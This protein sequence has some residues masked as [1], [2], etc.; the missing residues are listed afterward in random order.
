[1]EEPRLD[2][3]GIFKMLGGVGMFLYGMG[4]MS[5]GLK[6]VAGDNMRIILEKTTKNRILGT[7]VGF[8]VTALI[9]SSSATTVM[10]IGFVGAGMMS[11]LQAIGVIMGANIG[12]TVTAQIVALD[13]GSVAPIILFLGVIMVTFLGKPLVRNIG[14]I[15]LGFGLLFTGI[16]TMSAAISPLKENEAFTG[17]LLTLDNPFI[18]IMFGILFTAIVQSSSSSIGI[19]QAFAAQGLITF[20]MGAYFAVGAAIGA[21]V[22]AFLAA[23]SANRDGKRVA[24]MDLLFNCF[25]AVLIGALLSIFPQLFTLIERLSPGDVARQIA[26]AHTLF[27][28][29]AVIVQ[30]PLAQLLVKLSVKIL[31]L[32]EDELQKNERKLVY[33]TQLDRIPAAVALSQARRE[34]VRMGRIT[35]KNLRRSVD[36]FF[37]YDEKRI[38]AVFQEEEVI[39][40]LAREITGGLVTLRAMDLTLREQNLLGQML[41]VVADIERIGDHA[42]NIAEYAQ[43]LYNQKVTLSPAAVEELQQLAAASIQS[44][45]KSIQVYEDNAFDQ[46]KAVQ[47]LEDEIDEM[48]D[49]AMD[50]HVRRFMDQVCQ[51]VGGVIFTDMVTDLERCS[52]HAVNIAY[53]ITGQGN[54]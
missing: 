52:D 9:Q 25:R 34:I 5:D 17:M 21:C 23:L 37:T 40:W 13:L 38:S 33:L 39:N 11:L 50:A 45:D 18:A 24:I 46:L 51:P 14:K 10:V 36:V 35:E 19:V 54:P 53:A 27:A 28:I 44:I 3:F 49:E 31:P 1:M 6:A 2:L 47:D 15:I 42:E 43:R 26:N 32:R 4:I 48:K 16:S 8:L 30:L 7:L 12:T 41:L 22:P 20:R 29:T